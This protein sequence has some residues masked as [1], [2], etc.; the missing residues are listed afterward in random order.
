MRRELNIA[1][2]HTWQ[3][4]PKIP[5]F[6][7]LFFSVEDAKITRQDER[8]GYELTK[9]NGRSRHDSQTSISRIKLRRS[10]QMVWIK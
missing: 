6:N 1:E 10:D 3:R 4:V 2:P 9:A 5:S 8:R 7:S